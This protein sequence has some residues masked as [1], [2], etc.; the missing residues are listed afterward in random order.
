[1]R[2][3]PELQP[4]FDWLVDGAPGCD[5]PPKI[6]AELGRRLRDA[7]VPIDRINAFVRTLHP[8]IA[9]RRFHWKPGLEQAVVGELPWGDLDMP[10]FRAG[11]LPLVFRTGQEYRTSLAG[12]APLE[13]SELESLRP[14][15]LT[16]YLA[17]PLKFIGGTNNA[18]TFATSAPGG[19]T[20]AQ[21]DGLREITRPL[22]RVAETLALMRTAVNLLNTYV[23][24]NAGERILGGH[25]QPGDTENIRCVIWFSDLRGFT[26]M[27]GQSTPAQTIAVLNELFECQVPAIDKHGG[28]VLK[29]I[30]DGMLAIFPIGAA[31]DGPAAAEAAAKASAEAFA[32]LGRLNEER[33]AKGSPAIRFGLALHAGEVAYGNI[34]GAN[35]LDFTAIGSAVNLAARIESLTAKLQRDLLLSEDFAKLLLRPTRPAGSFELKGFTGPQAVFE[36]GEGA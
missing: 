9:G 2:L 33:A 16:D 15:G 1:M 19:F 13:H 22:S 6:V 7:A 35:R 29:F 4:L 11:P 3:P 5:T 14:Q 20:D 12:T 23:G 30:G 32:A 28:E 10:A 36:F 8:R 26:S 21:L 27:S 34:G 18:I 31:V 24:R 25:I 17:L